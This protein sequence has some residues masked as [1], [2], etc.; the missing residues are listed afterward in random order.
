MFSQSPFQQIGRLA[1]QVL[2]RP[3]LQRCRFSDARPLLD[4]LLQLAP[5]HPEALY[6]LDVLA[7]EEGKPEEAHA[8]VALALAA[9]RLGDKAEARQALEAALE[10]EPQN[11][12]ALRSLG[13]LLVIAGAFAA[14]V[15]RFRQALAVAPAD[16]ITTY[17]LAQALL[18]LDPEEHHDE[19][20]R[21]LLQVIQA[22]PPSVSIEVRSVCP[23]HGTPLC[24]D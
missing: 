11:S 20:D 14:G 2:N 12:F 13:S 3:T 4:T 8:Q 24:R 19:A 6:I 15:A 21:L 5:E 23:L 22:Q 18:Q 9:M 16:L 10:L 7:S 1:N 17:N